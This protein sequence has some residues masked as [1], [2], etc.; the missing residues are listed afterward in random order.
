MTK[1]RGLVFVFLIT[2]S[3]SFSQNSQPLIV[4]DPLGHTAKIEKLHFIDNGDKLISVSNDKTIRVWDTH[5]G[6]I[7]NK[8]EAEI[9]EGFEGVFYTSAIS[10]DERFLAAGGIA[11]GQYPENYVIIIDLKNGVQYGTAVGHTETISSLCF[12]PDSKMLVSGDESGAVF[13]WNI[14]G[15]GRF[16]NTSSFNLGGG[17]KDIA[18]HK[19][20]DWVVICNGSSEVN[21]FSLS[22]IVS[23][24]LN[25]ALVRQLKKHKH[26]VELLTF[27]PKN[28]YL[29]SAANDEM[30][31]SSEMILWNSNGEMIV[32]IPL[33]FPISDVSF[34]YDDKFLAV[35]SS[36]SG[37]VQIYELSSYGIQLEDV[38]RKYDEPVSALEFS[39]KSANGRDYIIASSNFINNHLSIWST[40]SGTDQVEIKG[41]GMVLN[42]LVYGL[43][44]HLYFSSD[45]GTPNMS[46]DFENFAVGND[47]KLSNDQISS[48]SKLG[49][50]QIND[51]ELLLSNSK[52][53]RVD[54]FIDGRI[55][56]FVA[57][58]YGNVVVGSSFSL[59]LFG[60][61]NSV[62]KEFRGHSGGVRA[63][64]VSPNGKYLF[65]SCEDQTIKIWNL[66]EKLGVPSIA[67]A[68][69]RN[70]EEK[71][72]VINFL[73]E[74]YKMDSVL[75]APGTEAW[76]TV[77][78][79]LRYQ[80]N[81]FYKDLN[82]LYND[83]YEVTFPFMTL[84]IS[85]D[86]EWVCWD[87]EGYF[88]CSDR[89][90]QYFGWHFNNGMDKLAS[91]YPARQYFDILFKPT[92][93]Q[94]SFETGVRINEIM[95]QTGQRPFDFSK[96]EEPSF[97]RIQIL[98]MADE[99]E[100]IEHEYGRYST[101][102]EK[103]KLKVYTYHKGS[104]VKELNIYRNNKLIT[105]ISDSSLEKVNKEGSDKIY[106]EVDLENGKNFFSVSAVNFGKVE[107]KR[108]SVPIN[109][110]G[111]PIL[112]S[113]LHVITV[114]INKYENEALNLNY[115]HSDAASFVEKIKQNDK[116]LYNNVN[117]VSLY[118]EDATK[119]KINEAFKA[120][121]EQ[122]KPNDVF[123]FYYAGHGQL[124]ENENYE[125]EYFLVPHDVTSFYDDKQNLTTNG[126]STSELVDNLTAINCS[127]Q[128][129]LLD[130]CQSGSAI[131][132]LAVSRSVGEKEK[133]LRQ[134][135]NKLGVTIISAAGSKQ[136]AT[137]FEDLGHGVFT[138]SILEA[139]D[140]KADILT[141]DN[142]ISVKELDLFL[143]SEVPKLSQ[144]FNAAAQSPNSFL[145]GVDFIIS[146]GG[147]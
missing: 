78:S 22:Q 85:S 24:N 122:T 121:S 15:G 31:K 126:I 19:D 54:P 2:I 13:L 131:E 48:Y 55:L 1:L 17:I 35:S 76:E 11:P 115:A 123:I 113:D 68:L 108:Y 41:K 89:G 27:S 98:D 39:P 49:I 4:V 74:N 70:V 112:T 45:G 72:I 109:Y 79:E 73:K 56:S 88:H 18:F 59:K 139:L 142:K 69:E 5:T 134:L 60:Q 117:I 64:A 81:D 97:A 100:G 50:R 32:Q 14:T 102:K 143:L 129:I 47:D 63:L 133:K 77:I 87:N 84:F 16:S 147:E 62:L 90:D 101:K 135:K 52:M 71:D 141:K 130:A 92:L 116:V 9:G 119:E 44:N 8:F 83:L 86:N 128:L 114:G 20:K 75:F 12:S 82:N 96:L 10:P 138:Y 125:S 28:G 110:T 46:F 99:D 95:R 33:G 94:K 43:N 58:N 103:I 29:L 42:R 137:E 61:N 140:G 38:Y 37:Q 80:K 145:E 146:A 65:S 34:S 106:V 124:R 26:Q 3:N 111:P 30:Y 51:Y 23:G 6:E 144:K 40:I 67:E 7:L 132:Y 107:S 91:F 118:D 136:F 36:S 21:I 93:I 57:D 66:E 105:T 53:I 25:R 120:V 127:N 104:G